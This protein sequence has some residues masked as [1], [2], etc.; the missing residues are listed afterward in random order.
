MRLPAVRP[1]GF[2]FLFQMGR[3]IR[4]DDVH[5]AIKG[6]IDDAGATFTLK[7][8]GRVELRASVVDMGQAIRTCMLQLACQA[9][10][11][12]PELVDLIT[13]DTALTHPHR[14]ASGERQTLIA[15]NAVVNAGKLFKEKI[16]NAVAGW[17]G[18]PALGGGAQDELVI[19]GNLIKTQWSQYQEERNVM[20]LAEVAQRA[21]KEGNSLIAEA[22]YVT[23]K[24]YP[25]SDQ[26]ARKTVPKKDYRNYPTYA[27]ATQVAIV[28]VSEAT[29][30]V[31]VLRVI[32]AHDV[33]VAINPQQI[34]GQIIG[35]IVQMQG[36]ALSEDYP[37]KEGRPLHKHPT[38][39]RLGAASSLDAPSVRVE[40]VEDPFPEGPFGAKGISEI[41]TVP[42][43]PAILNAV[44]NATGVRIYR[45]PVNP[46]A[47]KEAMTAGKPSQA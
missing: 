36:Y 16:L 18:I 28:E 38:F 13:G 12:A 10:G 34:R 44:H 11:L 14:S 41:A 29:G 27:Y 1:P 15:G 3:M 26:E 9:T 23:P 22:V 39:G 43:P 40:I 7:P 33:G 30:E 5:S 17:V 4:R 2:L 32:A 8:D 46:K 19:A 47:L 20:T 21:E 6:K 35:S 25:L 37:M 24:T 45:L 31:K 42:P